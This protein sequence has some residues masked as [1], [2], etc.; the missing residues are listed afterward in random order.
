MISTCGQAISLLRWHGASSHGLDDRALNPHANPRSYP[1]RPRSHA[2]LTPLRLGGASHGM[3]PSRCVDNWL[4]TLIP[5]SSTRL[6]HRRFVC[7]AM[8]SETAGRTAG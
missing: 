5:S 8:N 1:R 7:A 6:R 2:R 4:E 3:Y